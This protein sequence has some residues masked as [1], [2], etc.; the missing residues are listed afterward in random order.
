MKE[1]FLPTMRSF[2]NG[3]T[4]SGRCGPLRFYLT[5][6]TEEQEIVA[7]IWHG[8]YCREKSTVEAVETFPMTPEGVEALRAYLTEH[9][10]A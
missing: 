5:P 8:L 1:I 3:N 6:K 2:T 10:E 4:F 9:I 7:E